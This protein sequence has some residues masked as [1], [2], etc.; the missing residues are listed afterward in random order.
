MPAETGV[1][2]VVGAGPAGLAIGRALAAAGR[3]VEIFDQFEAPR[4]VGSGL[5]LQPVGLAAVRALDP[6][7]EA[8][9]RGL[10]A[11]IGRL[12]GRSVD[13]DGS[14]ARRERVALDAAYAGEAGSRAA[15]EGAPAT[16]ALGIHRAA[17]FETL[18]GR[19]I[20]AGGEIALGVRVV[21]LE[22]AGDGR[23]L[24][25]GADGR[26][27]GPFALV[28][29]AS[30]A[31]SPLRDMALGRAAPRPLAY[32][33]L[34]TTLRWSAAAGAR[35]AGDALEQRYVRASR[36]MGV[37]PVGR[38]T[39]EGPELLTFFWSLKPSAYDAWRARGLDV[40]REEAQAI[41][42][43]TAPLLAQITDPDQF[44]LARYAHFTLMRPY[45]DRLVWIGD[46]AHATSPQ[47]GQG[48]NMALLDA[49][50]LA[51]A[52]ESAPSSL[53]SSDLAA[54]LAGYARARRWHV[55]LYQLA[56][57]LFTPVFQSDGAALPWLRDRLSAPAARAPLLGPLISR[58]ISGRLVDPLGRSGPSAHGP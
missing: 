39:A 31:R 57:R 29:D 55:R 56:S 52:L 11:P 21:G 22:R 7:A 12:Y 44:D 48:A 41:W 42:P 46:S 14:G 6:P 17:L 32:G 33:A 47:L 40:W 2:A 5:M 23:P 35:F 13:A 19:L 54:A 30:G 38:M 26:R 16:P 15:R 36:M 8:Q 28:I 45:A 53:A 37:L 18:R 50:A 58:L 1:I 24:L 34:W 9:L 10:G 25:L 49:L 43:E 27:F 51:R 20:A 3:P 4:P